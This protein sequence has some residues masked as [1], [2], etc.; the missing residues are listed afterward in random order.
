MATAPADIYLR[1][2]LEQHKEEVSQKA[3][4]KAETDI[5]TSDLM[6]IIEGLTQAWPLTREAA[7]KSAVR[8]AHL[9]ETTPD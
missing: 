6:V 7:L 9:A 5:S 2:I 4:S 3:I 1:K 8:L